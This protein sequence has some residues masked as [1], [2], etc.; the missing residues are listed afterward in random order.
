MEIIL[1]D[2]RLSTVSAERL[3]IEGDVRRE[4]RKKSNRHSGSYLY[5]ASI[6]R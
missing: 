6:F 2:E 3:L 1:E 4:K 5:I